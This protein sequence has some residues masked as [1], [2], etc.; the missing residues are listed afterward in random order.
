MTG[1][2]D[3]KKVAGSQKLEN[4]R[5]ALKGVLAGSTAVAMAPTRWSKPVIESVVLPAHA[6]TSAEA[7]YVRTV[8]Q[9]NESYCV[10]LLGD[11]TADVRALVGGFS[12]C[13]TDTAKYLHTGNIPDD[14]SV[15]SISIVDAGEFCPPPNLITRG[16]FIAAVTESSLTLFI[17]RGEGGYFDNTLFRADSCPPMVVDD[18]PCDG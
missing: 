2:D 15:G 9:F 11:G 13:Q 17:E 7:I 1:K 8:P 12:H 6:A 4:R 3:G 10:T 18:C 14:S 5:K 16:A